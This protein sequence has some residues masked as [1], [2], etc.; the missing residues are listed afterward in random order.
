MIDL[1]AEFEKHHDVFLDCRDISGRPDLHAFNLLDRLLPGSKR[2]MVASAEHDEIWLDIDCGELAKVATSP[3]VEILV[4]CGVRDDRYLH[5]L[6][7][8]I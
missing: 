3:D 8:Y 4:R 7:L 6:S 2:N 1:A 5:S